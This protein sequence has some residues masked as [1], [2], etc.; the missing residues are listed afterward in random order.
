M[1]VPELGSI[2]EVNIRTVW[3]HEASCFTPWLADNISLLSEALGMDL[4]KGETEKQ[5]GSLFVDI[6][7]KDSAGQTV[8]IENQLEATNHDHLGRL[9]IYAAGYEA[10]IV[11]WVAARFTDEHRAAIE[12]L[13]TETRNRV[14]FYGAE[15]R[16]VKIGDSLPAPE[17]RL[18]VRPDTWS[19]WRRFFQPLMIRLREHGL[20]FSTQAKRW[21]PIPSGF[22]GISYYP[23]IAEIRP[24]PVE[25]YLQIRRD[26]DLA[27]NERIFSLFEAKKEDIETELGME[28]TW[29][30][31]PA[32]QIA[33]LGEEASLDD[34]PEKLERV[35]SWMFEYI[36]KLKQVFDR[37]LQEILGQSPPE[38]G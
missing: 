32:G 24:K 37:R 8:V 28:L 16:V 9:L 6:L 20:A 18:V 33:V 4:E 36:R 17:F 1:C 29:R 13:N 19:G 3:P 10:R 26:N 23:V 34:P 14:A 22:P 12:W 5:L 11:I 31:P 38:T 35:R 25:V 27:F 15:V 2:E 7:T 30:R 21:N